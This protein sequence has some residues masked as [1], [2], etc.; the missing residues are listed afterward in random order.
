[1][2]RHVAELIDKIEK[3]ANEGHQTESV[4]VHIPSTQE[5]EG[6]LSDTIRQC[7][8]KRPFSVDDVEVFVRTVELLVVGR[9]AGARLSYEL[10]RMKTT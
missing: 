6:P 1:M 8:T 10:S 4:S 9:E 7:R 5:Q 3:L 2:K